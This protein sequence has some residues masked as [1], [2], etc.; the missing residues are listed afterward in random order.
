MKIV[1]Q[2]ILAQNGD[3]RI[4]RMKV[5]AADIARKAAP[6]QFVVVM[7]DPKG[8]RIPLTIVERDP[9]AGTVTLIFQETGL[10]TRLLGKIP[11]GGS[12]FALAGPLGNPTQ[13]QQYGSVVVIGGGVGIAEAYPVAGALK[14]AGNR[15][16]VLIGSRTKSLLILEEELKKVSDELLVATDDGTSGRKGFVTDILKEILA[17]GACQLVYAVGPLPM[18]QAVAALTKSAGTKTIVSLNALMV[19]ATGMCGC[20]RVTVDGRTRFSCVDGPEFE[21]H[22]IDWDELTMRNKMYCKQEEHLCRL[23]LRDE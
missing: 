19:D 11:A 16:T 12:L 14:E 15:V 20:C 6:G 13:I 22:G 5:T 1:E 21:A 17:R 23:S 9:Q 7:A 10:T 2:G 8:E 4:V 18:M 3:T